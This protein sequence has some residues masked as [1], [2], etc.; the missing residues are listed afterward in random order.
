MRPST[1]IVEVDGQ[2]AFVLRSRLVELAITR[3]GAMLG[4]VQFFHGGEKTIQPYAIAPWAHDTPGPETDPFLHAIRG[5][6]FCSAFGDNGQPV[7]GRSIPPHGDT[8]HATWTPIHN[9]ASQSGVSIRLGCELPSQGGRCE[10]TT[11]LVEGHTIVYQRHDFTGIQTGAINPG[12]HAMLQFPKTEGTGV[13]SFSD[14]LFAE[15]VSAECSAMLGRT[16][17]APETVVHD[18]RRVPRS[19]GTETDLTIYPARS[20]FEDAIILCAHTNVPFAW[21]AAAFPTEG[22]VW[23]AL[24]NPKLLPSTL[25]WFWN[26]GRSTPPWNGHPAR[27]LGIE[28]I[29]GYFV[30]GLA[31]SA[32]PNGLTRRGV[33]TSI[34]ITPEDTFAIPYIQGVARIPRTFDRVQTIENEDQELVIRSASREV[35]RIDCFTSFLQH[36]TINGLCEA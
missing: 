4:P 34:A 30:D 7:R 33:P 8:V 17:L 14:F 13:L 3:R 15:T 24:R 22:Y 23:F 12:H 10:A 18:L 11:V 32:R 31:Q 9:L 2:L 35:V 21:S 5:D 29:M 20:G 28:D 16:S 36:G 25:L 27:V 1:A 19:D 26:G 6:F